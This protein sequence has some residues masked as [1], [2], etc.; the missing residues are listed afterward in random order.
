MLTTS[1]SAPTLAPSLDGI[2]S[3]E[4]PAMPQKTAQTTRWALTGA[5]LDRLLARLDPDRDR[6]ALK[7]EALRTR[8]QTQ[9]GW[10]GSHNP[11][12]LA[13]RALDRVATKLEEGAVVPGA[14]LPA[15][16]RRRGAGPPR[17]GAIYVAQGASL[18]KSVGKRVSRGAAT[19]TSG[20]SG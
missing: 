16:V 13:D 15:Y 4:V 9:M 2:H 5:A 12:E 19:S 10:W 6:A 17:S 18:G 20:P 3:A 8:L 11:L 1:W 7:Y 14:S